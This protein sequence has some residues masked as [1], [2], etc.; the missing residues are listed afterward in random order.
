MSRRAE[1]QM[2]GTQCGSPVCAAVGRAAVAALL[3][4]GS[5]AHPL[6]AQ[7]SVTIYN[8]GRLLVRR[9]IAAKVPKGS[10]THRIV[11][12][13]L[14]P[15]SIISLD[16]AVAIA[17]ARYNA[18]VG[19]QSVLRRAVGQTFEFQTGYQYGP[20]KAT[21]LGV[22]PEVW[23]LQDGGIVFYRPGQ[24]RYNDEMV[25]AQP[26]LELRVQ[27]AQPK[28]ALSLG[29]FTTGASWQATYSVVLEGARARIEGTASIPVQEVQFDSAE[30]QLLA[31]SVR[32]F[33]ALQVGEMVVT[34]AGTV[35]DKMAMRAP[36]AQEESVGEV[37][38]YSLPGRWTLQPGTTSLI[39]LFE[40]ASAPVIREYV[41]RRPQFF[42]GI[43]REPEDP[44][45]VPVSV[46]YTL[47]RRRG[48]PFGDRPVPGGT[49][50]IFDR[51]REGRLQLVGEAGVRHTPAGQDLELKAGNAF[52]LT[53]RRR[54]T[55]FTTERDSS[56]AGVR[57][58]A[59]AAY[60]VALTNARDSAVMVSVYEQRG[61][62]W[63]VTASSVP[64]DKISAATVRFRVAVP[65]RGSA[66]LTYRIRAVW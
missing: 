30:V 33:G 41:V 50:R 51:D 27:A 57:I 58:R 32:R 61:G 19:E 56:A 46:D 44:E 5:S 29:Y 4:F 2:N 55:E 22:N 24:L 16:P 62:E 9:E 63:A 26:A 52:D 43:E 20:L 59:T 3:L 13:R 14:E 35:A 66:T 23:R 36:Q 37:H 21:L 42:Y 31:G 60:E 38:V 53:A 18:D 1:E 64:P 65:P 11:I 48:S 8:D 39:P 34:G 10:S 25:V 45:Q 28:P 40:P 12:G 49:V 15:S 17:E 47:D 7:T 6:V 54:Q